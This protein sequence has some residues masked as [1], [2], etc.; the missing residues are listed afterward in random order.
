MPD[1]FDV[2][3]KLDRRHSVPDFFLHYD[4]LMRKELRTVSTLIAV[5]F[6]ASLLTAQTQIVP[7]ENKYSPSE[8][9][10]LGL[11]AAVEAEKQLP[12]MRDDAV[13]SYV[14]GIGQRLVNAI[15]PEVRHPE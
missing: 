13:T 1:G 4:L 6:S 11:Q 14:E 7:P 15:P 10:K 5:A 12:V 3:A 8:D 2:F 9:V